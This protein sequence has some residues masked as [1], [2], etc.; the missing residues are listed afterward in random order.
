[1]KRKFF[2]ATALTLCAMLAVFCFASC[3]DQNSSSGSPDSAQTTAAATET[4]SDAAATEAATNAPA[5][6]GLIGTWYSQEADG[7][8]YTFREDGKGALSGDDY[9]MAFT[10]VQKDS[11]VEI[12]YD[13]TP[14]T[15]T[16]NY[17]IDGDILSLEDKELGG[18]ITYKKGED[19][20]IEATTGVN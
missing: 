3:G 18:T 5:D 16:F 6:S 19:K 11:T 17:S 20:S 7:A 14:S 2:G 8:A 4:A 12:T 9:S 10:Y 1:M 15:Q 13:G